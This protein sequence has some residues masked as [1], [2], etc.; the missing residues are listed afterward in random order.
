MRIMMKS[1]LVMD[2]FTRALPE[3][4]CYFDA[5]RNTLEMRTVKPAK[6]HAPMIQPGKG[7]KRKLLFLLT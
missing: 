5:L 2:F 7:W 4:A 6:Q 3:T 1:A